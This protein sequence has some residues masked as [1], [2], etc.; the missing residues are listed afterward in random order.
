MKEPGIPTVYSDFIDLVVRKVTPEEIIAFRFPEAVQERVIDL[1]DRQDADL[2][3]N[4]EKAELEEMRQFDRLVSML[5]ARA[6]ADLH[7]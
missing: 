7:R 5:K 6:L 4:E 2:L 1:L 3:N